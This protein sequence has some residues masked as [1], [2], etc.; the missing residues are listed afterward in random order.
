VGEH[1]GVGGRVWLTGGAGKGCST[2]ARGPRVS[3]VLR[4]RGAMAARSQID[5]AVST[6]RTKPL[7]A[8]SSC[9]MGD[10]WLR[11]ALED[12][13]YSSWPR[14]AAQLPEMR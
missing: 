10:E 7:Y 14:A 2:D 13:T 5:N 6:N 12:F 1:A 9:Q 3:G 8:N 4:A 11:W